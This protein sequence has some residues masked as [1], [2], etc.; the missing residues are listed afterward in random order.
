MAKSLNNLVQQYSFMKR[1]LVRMGKHCFMAAIP[2]KWLKQQKL[3][4]G[5]SIEFEQFESYLMLSAKPL[6]KEKEIS[7]DFSFETYGRAG[8]MRVLQLLYDS[9]FKTIKI[10]FNDS[11]TLSYI[12]WVV[13]I[14][15]GWKLTSIAKNS[16]KIES[17]K[18][19]E[20]DFNSYFRRIF[21]KTKELPSLYSDY[22]KGKK[23]V[24]DEIR[25]EYDLILKGAMEIKRRINT[26]IL[27]L[28]YKYYY[29]IAIN[30][31][32]IADHYEFLLR[33]LENMRAFPKELLALNK[34]LEKLMHQAYDNFYNFSIKGFIEFNKEMI[35][36]KFET[37]ESP[38]LVYHLRAIS[39]RIKNI[40]K[41][42]IGIRVK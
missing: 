4:K 17:V 32:E 26:S 9:G 10:S 41:Y 20:E 2:M 3:G 1:K 38:L 22:L 25:V 6:P 13:R 7:I 23:E 39:E 5:D 29:F 36:K 19:E 33:S 8:I 11:K 40:A 34:E 16:C 21:L 27:P 24:I 15:E 30:L 42:T 31:E 28:E 37:A 14:L 35:W 18:S 12:S